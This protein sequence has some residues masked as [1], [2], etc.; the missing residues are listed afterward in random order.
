MPKRQ[1]ALW[2]AVIAELAEKGCPYKLKVIDDFNAQVILKKTLVQLHAFYQP[3]EGKV[4]GEGRVWL[5]LE[6]PTKISALA[7]FCAEKERIAQHVKQTLH[8]KHALSPSLPIEESEATISVNASVVSNHNDD[9]IQRIS[10]WYAASIA[11]MLWLHQEIEEN[12]R[13]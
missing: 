13:Y 8:M 5:N 3:R 2:K 6:G 1:P 4:P 10:I 12:K 7:F 9:L 11:S